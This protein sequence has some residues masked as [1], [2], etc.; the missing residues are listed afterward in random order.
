MVDF[1]GGL[2]GSAL[3]TSIQSIAAR[4][5]VPT[6]TFLS[7]QETTLEQVQ[8]KV[9]NGDVWAAV[10]ANAGQTEVSSLWRILLSIPSCSLCSISSYPFFLLINHTS[11]NQAFN[12]YLT[13]NATSTSTATPSYDPSAAYT[14]TGLQTRYFTVWSSYVLPVLLEAT[15]TAGGIVNTALQSVYPDRSGFDDARR[16][17]LANPTGAT[18]DNV[19]PMPFTVRVLVSCSV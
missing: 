14:Y 1:D 19:S 18:F 3:T 12:S 8:D 17:V 9:W 6:F 4:P 11:S 7:A 5:G 15:G 2:I 10:W 16:S 13:T